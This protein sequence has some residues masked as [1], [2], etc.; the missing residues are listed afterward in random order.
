MP[1]TVAPAAQ[2]APLVAPPAPRT[3]PAVKQADPRTVE[4][5]R[6]NVWRLCKLIGG[7]FTREEILRINRVAAA[8]LLNAGR[9]ASEDELT[10]IAQD[11]LEELSAGSAAPPV[12]DAAKDDRE[13]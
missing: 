4:I 1:A 11:L 2:A 3:A 5:R 10:E 7:P 9:E 6:Q 13:P 12:A 8:T